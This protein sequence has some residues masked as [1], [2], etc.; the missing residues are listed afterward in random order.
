MKTLR[1]FLA[2]L[3]IL[4]T[5]SNKLSAQSL[6]EF[7]TDDNE[8]WYFIQFQNGGGVL[9]DMGE[10][11]IV[12]TQKANLSND[13]QQWKIVGSKSNCEII[14]KNGRHLYYN[15]SSRNDKY[16]YAAS[17]S[18]TGKLRLYSTT[19]K[20]APAWEIQVNGISGS[21]M[22]QWG[23][24][25]IGRELGNWDQNDVNNPVLFVTTEELK[26][27]D[28]MPTVLKEYSVS[29]DAKYQPDNCLTLWYQQPV[30]SQT[31]SDIWMD[32][33]LPIGN[34]Q[35]GA[36]IYGGIRQDIVQ[37][38][39]KTLWEGS[40]TERGAYQNFGH[41]YIEDLSENFSKG[42]SK[43]HRQL[44]LTTAT[45]SAS[46]TDRD[47]S[48]TYHRE[49][50]ASNPDQCIVV[51]LTAS[52]KG[53]LSQRFYLYNPH[54][55][56]AK[57]SDGGGSFEGR[58]TTVSYKAGFQVIAEGGT[59]STDKDGV[60]VTNADEITVVLSG[61][62]D[63]SPTA[64]GYVSDTK[65]LG[66]RISKTI[67]KAA[68]KDWATLYATHLADYKSLFD[69]VEL[70]LGGVTNS[71]PTNRLIDTYKSTKLENN[72]RVLEQLYFQF[73]RYL[74]IASSRGV[75]L[76][77]NLQ[78]IWNNSNNPPWDCDMHANINVQMNYWAA[79]KTNLSELHDKYL[80]YLYNMSQVQPQW[81]SY[82][83][84]RAGISAGWVNFTENNVFGH[85][86]YWHNDYLEAGAWSFDHLWQHYRY[87]QDLDFLRKTA[88][89][90]MLSSVRFWMKRL[91]LDNDKLWVCPDEWSPEHGP[92]RTIT[93]HAQ[94]IVWSL[95]AHTIEGVE[96]LG[97][98]AAGTTDKELASIKAKFE[99]L[100]DGL[101]IEKYQGN[102]GSERNGVRTGDEILKEWKYVDFASG[103]GGE[104]DHRHLSHLMALYPLNNLSPSSQYY[105]PAIRALML[106]GLQSQGWSMGWKMNLW[107]RAQNADMCFDI[108]KLAF[109]HSADYVINMSASAGGVYYN[110]L[111]S[112]SPFQIDGNFGVCAGMAEMLMQNVGDTILLL[113]ALPKAW[114]KGS[115]KGLKAEGNFTISQQWADGQI[116]SATITSQAGRPCFIRGE[117]LYNSVITDVNGNR[118]D[119][120]HIG[121]DGVGFDTKA[122]ETYTMTIVEPELI[123]SPGRSRVNLNRT[124]KF[125]LGDAT[126]AESVGFD[127]KQWTDTNLP[128]SFSIPYFM[129]KDVYHGYG[130]YRKTLN[131]GEDWVNKHFS[132]EFEGSFIETEVYLNG[133]KVGDHVG[134]YTGFSFDLTPYIHEGEN[135]LAVRINNL[136]NARVAPRAGDHQFSVGIY[137][138][139]WLNVT[140]HLRVPDNGTFI[141]TK[142]ESTESADVF[143]ETEIRNDFNTD[144]TVDVVTT[145]YDDDGTE[146][147]NTTTTTTIKARTISI[148]KQQME[149]IA[150]P[151]LWSPESPYRY[152]AVTRILNDDVEVDS[153][154]TRF[155]IRKMVWTANKGF[156]LNDKHYYL[157]GANVHQDQA[158]WGDAVTNGA[159][160]RDVQ[161]MK[162]CGFNC[163][164]ASHYPH[165]PAFAQACDSI[166]VI[167]FME[168]NFW[169]MGGNGDEGAWGEGAPAS[170]YPTIASD[171]PY[172]EES[173][174]SQLK[175][176]I[177][178]HRNSP[179]IAC[180]SLS[181]EPFFCSSSVDD[182]MKHLLCLEIDSA[183]MWDPSREV[184]IG[185]AQRKDIDK[186]G[187]GAIAFYNGD[188]ASR[189]DNQNPGVPNLVSE[190]GSPNYDRPGIF[191]P[192]WGDVGDGYV[193][194]AWR[195]GQVI[196]C[197]FDHGTVGGYGL[198]KDGLVD[199][200]RIPKRNYYWY[201][202]AYKK[203][204]RNPTE[205]TWP[206]SGKAAKLGLSASQ[207]TIPS[208]DGTDDS[209]ILVKILNSAGKPISNSQPVTLRIVSGPGEFPTGRSIT[210]TPPTV[211]NPTEVSSNPQC[212]IR[213]MDGQAAIAF[214][215]YYAGETIIEA[216]SAGLE[217][218]QIT[219]R[220]LGSPEW[221]EGI[222][223][224]VPDRPYKRYN[225]DD[226]NVGTSVMTL[227]EQRPTWSSSDMAGTNKINANDG[228]TSTVWKPAEDDTERWWMVALEGQ[229]TVNRIELTFPDKGNYCYIVEVANTLG[230]WTKVIDQ[231]VTTLTD[232][233]QMAVGKF[234]EN[235][236]YVR[237]TFTSELAGLAEVRVGGSTE[238][239]TLDDTFLGGT[240]I[241][242][243]GSWDNNPE[244]TITA[245][246]D[247]NS[248]TFFDGPSGS[249][250]YWVGLDLG[251]GTEATITSVAY[252]P[253]YN[254]DSSNFA[255]RMIGGK[256]Q[257]A[258]NAT[259]KNP[260]TVFTIR[261][262]PKY[263][264]FTTAQSTNTTASGRYVRYL[265]TNSGMGNVA[266]LQF[267]GIASSIPSAIDGPKAWTDDTQIII[268]AIDRR[269]QI[270]GASPNDTVM[271]YDTS[272]RTIYQGTSHDIIV[273]AYG[274]YVVKV[275]DTTQTLA[276]IKD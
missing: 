263:K 207:T 54:G 204:K 129:W 40:P 74:L 77:N 168:T 180:W 262:T 134:G 18:Q 170:S 45:A 159:I 157:L 44:D 95:F 91:K 160:A 123:S 58:L 248:S 111:D 64:S 43:Y 142:N 104:S 17:A 247:F 88:M 76:P 220:T 270:F 90:V 246:M 101:Y 212:D 72:K 242:T 211:T 209:Q 173:V 189:S 66:E 46:W 118:I 205:P 213:I 53:Q 236:S 254:Q 65:I 135:V 50:I 235:I 226:V 83:R 81:Q 7:S 240:I 11:A 172:F 169:G 3:L 35:L 174:L 82:A 214:R 86:T 199:Y 148:V 52:E 221:R 70:D 273:P 249:S 162:D 36:M 39:D 238:A 141:Y 100:D 257:V 8:V 63:Y 164:R 109:R 61:G 239:S 48:V 153:Y 87:T 71:I 182:K 56:K 37:F 216:T 237:V 68:G 122:G 144:Q 177:R 27:M 149:G 231:S 185:G 229:Y 41:L 60:T 25:G 260:T 266:E 276:L 30:T 175:E 33:A 127:D 150:S 194:P 222:D 78:G 188:G 208:C 31:C 38:N 265:S 215:S 57:Y 183:R 124:W 147:A 181:N 117:G 28:T 34:G 136:W 110:L 250:S 186:L 24:A 99:K 108:F 126:G 20:Y 102:Y 241:G 259:F 1:L 19:T 195:S 233:T 125:F 47:G 190:Y 184:A 42:V 138:D 251:Y 268:R 269:I 137:R 191:D 67:S 165:D 152:K 227:C 92:D 187:K 84:D 193:R 29:T 59:L 51:H 69:R 232:K 62:T 85:C 145:I 128:H 155:G 96:L 16:R 275:N 230:N 245:A 119:V 107:A 113:P 206:R 218:D 112:H 12:K 115:V 22:N 89:P 146:V 252:M 192:T 224:P 23:G 6:P 97:V 130:W 176:E 271:V 79:E 49:Y 121:Y 106:R 196:W 203:G 225:A 228:S 132:I 163:I 261:N 133:R 243:A 264:E 219:I 10:G 201:V 94:Q 139:V 131:V 223:K 105:M 171:Q 178:I 166:G 21:S 154:S 258:D 158:G 267:Y 161:L 256:F 253:R 255:E 114:A 234:G 32:Y 272:G 244:T 13:S 55:I 167:L 75:D 151:H 179:S 80:N 200:F 26:E 93:A 15:G 73:G 210:F 98:D 9:Q 14:S 198:A 143:A 197:G 156:F 116:I 140:D 103:N 5:A 120:D 274:I 4:C 2:S 217:S 202:E